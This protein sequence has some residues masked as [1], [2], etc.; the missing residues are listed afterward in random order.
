[1]SYVY[2]RGSQEAQADDDVAVV[3][4]LVGLAAG[5]DR[6]HDHGGQRQPGDLAGDDGRVVAVHLRH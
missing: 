2:Q 4:E 5:E 1:M 6:E 3:K